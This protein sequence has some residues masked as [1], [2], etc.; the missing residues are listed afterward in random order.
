MSAK[1]TKPKE[2]PL[3]TSITKEAN[4][5]LNAHAIDNGQ[6]IKFIVNKLI[7]DNL[8]NVKKK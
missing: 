7:I 3:S 6:S 4:I 5:L 1:K 2:V 8:S